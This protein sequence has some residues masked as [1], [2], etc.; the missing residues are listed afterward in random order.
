MKIIIAS[1]NTFKLKEMR[2]ILSPFFD[3]IQSLAEAGIKH[4]TVEDGETF[5]ENAIKKAREIAEITGCCAIADDSGLCVDALGGLP[6]VYSARFS[7][8]HGDYDACNDLLLEKMQ[9]I[10][11]R[12][13]HY[14]CAVAIAW[15]DG[16]L[17]TAEDYLDGQIA[18]GKSGKN[19]FSYDSLFVI[20]PNGVRMAEID[21]EF[22]NEISHRSKALRKLVEKISE[23]LH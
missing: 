13:A 14:T 20:M 12:S 9:G 1:N 3:N 19:G 8:K 15:P 5:M 10:E 17:I 11:K 2:A 18:Y 6:G 22:K 16:K 23:D 4:E 7:G 21:D